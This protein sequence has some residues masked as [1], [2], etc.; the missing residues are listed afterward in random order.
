MSAPKAR[1]RTRTF[2]P[3]RSPRRATQS[4]PEKQ[5]HERGRALA[6]GDLDVDD[7]G[8]RRDRA[9]EGA[10]EVD[11][12]DAPGAAQRTHR[13]AR[14]P[15]GEPADKRDLA[16]DTSPRSSTACSG[17]LPAPDFSST[18]TSEL[19]SWALACGGVKEARTRTPQR[20]A[21][22][23]PQ[24]MTCVERL[25]TG[26]VSARN[27]PPLKRWELRREASAGCGSFALRGG[28][29]GRRLPSGW[30]FRPRRTGDG[31]AC[32][33]DPECAAVLERSER[34]ARGAGAS[35]ADARSRVIAV[36]VAYDA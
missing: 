19:R 25:V 17:R 4:M 3:S 27:R 13:A 35:G 36:C 18:T 20:T 32:A 15:G 11:G 30:R 22:M 2:S 9:D 10:V 33:D 7:P 8:L 26:R 31:G 1:L 23:I 14:N 5:A 24:R 29:F 6:V 12:P 16:H 34:R 21:R 28:S